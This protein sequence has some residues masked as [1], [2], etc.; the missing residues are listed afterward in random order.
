MIEAVIFDFDG[1]ILDTET[2]L[3]EAWRQTYARY[4]CA[5]SLE[6]WGA[7]VGGH[8]YEAFHPLEYLVE[9][10][11]AAFDAKA[12]DRARYE[13]YK[14]WVWK[15]EAAPGAGALMAALREAGLAVGVASSSPRHWVQGHME[16]LGLW[17]L[18]E[19]GCF[20]DEVAAVK[21][22]PGVYLKAI[23]TLGV[24]PRA[25]CALED[26]P[27]GIAAA[28]AAGLY[29]IAVANPVTAIL[30]LSGA[31]WRVTSLEALRVEH[32]LTIDQREKRHAV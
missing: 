7:N 20:G 15:Q 1:L 25:A 29:C 27:K 32:L 19:A 2:T 17:S 28:K 11:N 18:L 16:R 23:E 24:G 14:E 8:S 4:G 3:Y 22:D 12:V 30:D 21:P 6:Q 9:N 13:Q 31:D 10:A 5:L 26:S